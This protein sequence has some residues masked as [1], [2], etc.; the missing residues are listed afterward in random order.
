MGG[1]CGKIPHLFQTFIHLLKIN[2]GKFTRNLLKRIIDSPNVVF[3]KNPIFCETFLTS[4]FSF[5]T[6]DKYF[7]REL[8]YLFDNV[9]IRCFNYEADH[10]HIVR[11]WKFHFFLWNILLALFVLYLKYL[12]QTNIKHTRSPSPYEKNKNSVMYNG[13]LSP[14]VHSPTEYF[15]KF[16]LSLTL[17]KKSVRV[18]SFYHPNCA[19]KTI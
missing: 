19:S 15:I 13:Y 18:K 2:E 4:L 17:K 9:G 10:R 12:L 6:K 16:I 8:F 1:Y 3:L 14:C 5:V 11:P 7:P